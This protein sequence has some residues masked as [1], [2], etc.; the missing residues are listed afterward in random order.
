MRIYLEVITN[1]YKLYI[2][3]RSFNV[4]NCF[5]VSAEQNR[6]LSS[7]VAA[8]F[9]HDL[10]DIIDLVNSSFS[11]PIIFVF[12]HFFFTNLIAL[13]NHFWVFLKDF[14]NFKLIL[15]TEGLW[16]ILNYILQSVF[17]YLI[18]STS[19]E[20]EKTSVIVSRIINAQDCNES[21]RKVFKGFLVQNQCRNLKLRTALFGINWSLLL[22]VSWADIKINYLC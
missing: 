1:E 8:T 7:R 5:I 22:S 17:V 15:V 13:F 18:I 21:H 12:L 16:I 2:F 14:R 9:Y 6:I 19:S 20:A 3:L 10:C 11:F 4:E